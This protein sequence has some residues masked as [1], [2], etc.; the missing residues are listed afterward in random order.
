MK[1]K[2]FFLFSS[3]GKCFSATSNAYGFIRSPFF[4]SFS[5]ELHFETQVKVLLAKGRIK[6]IRM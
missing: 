6:S 2:V 1:T 4:F 5:L 3:F